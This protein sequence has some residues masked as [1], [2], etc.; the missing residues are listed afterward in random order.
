[1]IQEYSYTDLAEVATDAQHKEH[2][3]NM[4]IAFDKFCEQHNLT[5]Y[6]SG[7]TLLGAV[8]HKGFIPW[9]DDIDINMPRP[10]CEKLMELSD[11]RIGEFQFAA[12]NHSQKY[13]AYH[14]KLY[15]DSILVAK[16]KAGGIGKKVYPIFLDIFPID[17]LPATEQENITHYANIITAKKKAKHA[18]GKMVYAGR[19]PVKFIRNRLARLYYRAKGV[20]HYFDQVISIATSIPYTESE[21]IGVMMT[22]V[23]TTEERVVKAEYCPIIKLE[24]E[25]HMFCCPAGYDRYLQQLYGQDYMELLPPHKR[26]SKHALV[27]F[28]RN[29]LL[30]THI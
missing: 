8:R 4:L 7:G 10:D 2:L 17:G 24:F 6:L 9:D 23:H 19:N 14:W 12:P 27:P 1:M 18:R 26:V 15:D 5:Y 25:G 11:G 20:E 22:N 30:V 29:K 3:L 28:L 16:R 21:H 13:F